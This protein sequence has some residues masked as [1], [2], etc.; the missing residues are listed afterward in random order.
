MTRTRVRKVR[1]GVLAAGVAAA[2]ATAV[3]GT[4]WATASA[5][6][7]ARVHGWQDA[8]RASG[9][10]TTSAAGAD[11]NITGA[12]RLVFTAHSVA[13]GAVDTGARGDSPGDYFVFEERLTDR[14]G[15]RIGRDSARCMLIVTTFRCDGTFF[16]A[17]RGSFEVSGSLTGNSNVL[18]VTGGTGDF[19][20]ARGQ[21][22]IV[23]GSDTTTDFVVNLLP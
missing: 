16:L 23:G 22:R 12:E 17:G 18:A 3:L 21:A 9:A 19:R 10:A 1:T 4:G 7:S 2:A 20:N 6:S 15:A 11:E 14:G 13:G 8:V 5:G